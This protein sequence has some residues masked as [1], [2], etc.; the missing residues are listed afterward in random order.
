MDDD[1]DTSNVFVSEQV[2]YYP[3]SILLFV[4]FVLFLRLLCKYLVSDVCMGNLIF[5]FF[6]FLRISLIN[7]VN[8]IFQRYSLLRQGGQSAKVRPKVEY[9]HTYYNVTTIPLIPTALIVRKCV[10]R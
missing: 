1:E 6:Q 2:S 3:F 9:P 10:L 7:Y 4:C 8:F 5:D